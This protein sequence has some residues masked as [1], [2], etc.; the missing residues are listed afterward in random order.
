MVVENQC[1]FMQGG[2]FAVGEKCKWR[3]C[4][5]LSQGTGNVVGGSLDDVQGQCGGHVV[6]VGNHSKLSQIVVR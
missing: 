6:V 1:Q 2:G 4:C 3:I 5:V